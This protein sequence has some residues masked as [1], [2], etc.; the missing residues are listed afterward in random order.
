MRKSPTQLCNSHG[1]GIERNVSTLRAF[2]NF[3]TKMFVQIKRNNYLCTPKR[4]GVK[5]TYENQYSIICFAA[6]HD[7]FGRDC[8]N[9]S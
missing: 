4:K 3:Y 8:D 7:C 6:S 2:Y 1:L 5:N 9:A